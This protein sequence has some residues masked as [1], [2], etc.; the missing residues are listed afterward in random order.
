[1]TVLLYA[2]RIICAAGQSAVGK[3]YAR[4][5]GD[6]LS[7][8]LNKAL[9]GTVM[10]LV[11]GCITGFSFHLPTVLLGLGYG[12][13]FCCAMH[14]GFKALSMG[15]MALTSMIASFSLI[16]PFFFGIF[17]WNE[18]LT[19]FKAFG[20]V[21]LLASILLINA[22]KE[23][24]FSFL[25]LLYALLTLVADGVSSVVQ[26]LHQL[27]FPGLYRTEFMSWALL[28]AFVILAGTAV[29]TK[30]AKNR[31]KFSL[32]G[33]TAGA[34]NCSSDYI[35]L[36][37]SATESAS[38]LFPIVSIANIIA[39][40]LIGVVIFKERLRRTQALGLIVGVA[41]VVLLKM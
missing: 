12:L 34:M 14:T 10:F 32:L 11:Y 19:G 9:S 18:E 33:L 36:Y 5:G 26:K 38:V 40:W 1:M 21:L 28:C 39:V 22:K 30:D 17:L 23:S 29:Q 25:W 7:F 13:A 6:S 2:M 27:Q 4:L 16:I 20:I 35:V 31:V 15:P 8:N 24:G 41:S 37:L 3:Q